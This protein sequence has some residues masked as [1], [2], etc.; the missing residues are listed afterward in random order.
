MWKDKVR[1]ID[2]VKVNLGLIERLQKNHTNKLSVG[3]NMGAMDT[4]GVSFALV[5]KASL[6]LDTKVWLP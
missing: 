4:M 1:I 3:V 5:A 6:V 2:L